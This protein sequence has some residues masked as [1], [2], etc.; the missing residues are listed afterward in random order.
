MH[1]IT[2]HMLDCTYST[3]T[4]FG[5]ALQSTA[6]PVG[7]AISECNTCCEPVTYQGAYLS[8]TSRYK[9]QKSAF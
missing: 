3:R 9:C 2:V 5:R 7:A 6:A 8:I 1:N 4:V